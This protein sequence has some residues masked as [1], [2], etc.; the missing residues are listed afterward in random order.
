VTIEGPGYIAL[1]SAEPL[2]RSVAEPFERG[3]TSAR[4]T[5]IPY[6]AWANRGS[7]AMRVWLPKTIA[8]GAL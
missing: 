4:I 7:A 5:A 8:W 1:P 6:Y 2:Y 3:Y